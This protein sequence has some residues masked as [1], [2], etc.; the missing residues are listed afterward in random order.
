MFQMMSAVW[1]SPI[2][3]PLARAASAKSEPSSRPSL[4][5]DMFAP[6]GEVSRGW[7][8]FHDRATR[9][10]PR[11]A[12]RVPPDRAST[13]LR[14]SATGLPR[15]SPDHGAERAPCTSHIADCDLPRNWGKARESRRT[16][17][18]RRRPPA[19]G[20]LDRT[21]T[22][23]LVLRQHA[24]ASAGGPTDLVRGRDRHRPPAL[25]VGAGV[26]GAVDRV[27]GVVAGHPG[28]AVVSPSHREP[29]AVVCSMAR[30]YCLGHH[31]SER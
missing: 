11:K 26:P 27:A 17:H 15:P 18:R 7:W 22:T 20:R 4:R 16:H 10:V 1:K 13:T 8:R 28:G 14:R 9:Q 2:M 19:D 31:D 3:T 6:V 23:I 12:V 29:N 5:P 24:T 25:A 21:S 30:P